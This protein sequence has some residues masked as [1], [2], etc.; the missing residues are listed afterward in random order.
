MSKSRRDLL[1][2]RDVRT[3]HTSPNFVSPKAT[4]SELEKRASDCERR[5]A[6]AKEPLA[7]QLRAEAE[8]YRRWAASLRSGRW[9]E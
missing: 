2:P 1:L 4:I 6:K 9:T 8:S 3:G 7:S 5:A